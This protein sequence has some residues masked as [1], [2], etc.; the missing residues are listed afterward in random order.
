MYLNSRKLISA[1]T[2][3]I[4]TNVIRI[5]TNSGMIRNDKKIDMYKMAV[6]KSANVGRLYVNGEEVGINNNMALSPSSVDMTNRNWLGH[7]A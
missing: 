7:S 6:T 4:S 5:A 3:S 1:L 2:K